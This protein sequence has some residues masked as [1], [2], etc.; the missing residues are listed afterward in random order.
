MNYVTEWTERDLNNGFTYQWNPDDNN[1]PVLKITKS[2]LGTYGF[3]RASYRMSYDP[4][5]E[6]KVS[7]PANEAMLRGTE[8]HDAQEDFWKAVDVDDAMNYIDDPNRLAKSF[9]DLYP[10][11]NDEIT[12]S[13]YRSMASWSAERFIDC[14]KEGIVEFF[15]P[16]GNEVRLNAKIELN[17]LEIH[18]QGIIDR[19]FIVDGGYTPLELKTG[20]WKDSKATHMRK[21]MAFY[22]ILFDNATD[23]DKIEAGLDP[24]MEFTNWGWFFPASNYIFLEPVKARTEVSVEKAM[25]KLVDSYLLMEFPYDD[26]YKKCRACGL[27]SICEKGENNI[28]YDW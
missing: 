22:K 21:E 2:S 3:C 20:V 4:L 25:Q 5:G 7:Q 16:V 1:S 11:T 17:G 10:K 9:L 15:K 19:L 14:V 27:Y 24:E 23:E 26:F 8:A 28:G 18:L 6:G 12:S 13:L